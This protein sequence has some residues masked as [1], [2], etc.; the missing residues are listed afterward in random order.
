[1]EQAYVNYLNEKLGL[2]S[3]YKMDSEGHR[4][5]LMKIAGA[6]LLASGAISAGIVYGL[7]PNMVRVKEDRNDKIESKNARIDQKNALTAFFTGTVIGTIILTIPVYSLTSS[8]GYFSE[9]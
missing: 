3:S 8:G 6:C 1:M 9:K 7:K 5:G 4:Y 2:K